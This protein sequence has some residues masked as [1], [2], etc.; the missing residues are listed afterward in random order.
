MPSQPSL[1]KLMKVRRDSIVNGPLLSIQS[2][3]Q[4]VMGR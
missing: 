2:P 3:M 1:S 4:F